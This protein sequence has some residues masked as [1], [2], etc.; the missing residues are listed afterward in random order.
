MAVRVL[1]R[2]A[3]LNRGG[4]ETFVMNVYRA[5]DRSKVQFDFLLNSEQ[6]DYVE[7]AKSLGANIYVIPSRNK[8]FFEYSKNLDIF[9]KEHA[10]KY[11]AIHQH[12]PTLSSIDPLIYAK[13]HGVKTRIIHAHSSS[14][15]GK[16]KL[17]YILHAINKYRIGNIATH[18]YVC[19]E[20]ANDWFFN[21]TSLKNKSEM[22]N[23]GIDA[24]KYVFDHEIRDKI[25]N[26]FGINHDTVVLGHVGRFMFVKNHLF[27]L[28]IFDHYHKIN[29][30]S[31][32][33]LIGT[34]ELFEQVKS[35]VEEL[36]L[37]DSVIFTGVRGDVN[38]LMMAMDVF[39]MPSLFEGLPMVLVEAQA[40]GLLCICSDTI[41]TDASLTGDIKWMSL[42]KFPNEWSDLILKE[43]TQHIRNNRYSIICKKGFDIS[44]TANFL[45]NIYFQ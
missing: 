7:E 31:K 23:N 12:A 21:Y 15:S 36:K 37:K 14:L 4:L 17:H 29:P 39:V 20:K 35:K 34:G 25:R 5:I 9:F 1:Q 38:E 2:M 45:Q 27:L 6:G 22:I 30:N 13:K 43:L 8:G 10:K 40:T 28:D 16:S 24:N 32:L 42:D 3:G 19:S 26:E 44:T 11:V 41:S 18:Y 33:L